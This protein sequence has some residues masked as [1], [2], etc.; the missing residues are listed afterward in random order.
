MEAS[1]ILPTQQK[2]ALKTICK[3]D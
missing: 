2:S 1:R 3:V